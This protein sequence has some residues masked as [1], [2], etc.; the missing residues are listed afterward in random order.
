MGSPVTWFEINSSNPDDL[1]DFYA[2]A[3]GWTMEPVPG[4]ASATVDTGAGSGISGTIGAADGANQVT[5]YIEVD[6]PEAYLN[7]VESLGGTTVVPVTEI[8]DVVTFAQ[9]SD[10]DGN[11]LGLFK[12]S[13]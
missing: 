13:S 7:R 11:V 10:P 4:M 2:R 8:P 3:F 1:Y 12:S 9:F 6:D 5:F